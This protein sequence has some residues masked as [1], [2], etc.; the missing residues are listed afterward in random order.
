M[1]ATVTYRGKEV[2]QDQGWMRGW[3]RGHAPACRC[4]VKDPDD[5]Y[6]VCECLKSGCGDR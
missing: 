6:D 5:R 2:A 3:M 1:T 4:D